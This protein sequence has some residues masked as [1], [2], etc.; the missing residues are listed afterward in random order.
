LCELRYDKQTNR[1]TMHNILVTGQ[2]PTRIIPQEVCRTRKQLVTGQLEVT[3][4]CHYIVIIYNKQH[5]I[6]SIHN[7]LNTVNCNYNL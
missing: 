5:I 2:D 6:A 4:T 3:N 1:L 7:V